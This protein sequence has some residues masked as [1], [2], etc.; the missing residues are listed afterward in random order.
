[1]GTRSGVSVMQGGA[2]SVP[3]LI[4]RCMS[5]IATCLFL[6]PMPAHAAAEDATWICWHGDPKAVFCQLSGT[7]TGADEGNPGVALKTAAPASAGAEAALP[8]PA[9]AILHEPDRLKGHRI[10][11]PM[12]TE[13]ESRAFMIELVEAVMCGAKRN[14]AVQFLEMGAPLAL[15]L[16][17][18]NDPAL[19]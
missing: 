14:C 10:A 6:K 12:L 8:P 7:G 15:L 16:D 5:V 9:R 4:L 18:F 17:E 19:N 13:P 3:L 2:M 1:M 11:V